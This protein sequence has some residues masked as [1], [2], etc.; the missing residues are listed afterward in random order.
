MKPRWQ[1]ARN[2]T[3]PISISLI[4]QLSMQWF[5]WQLSYTNKTHSEIFTSIDSIDSIDTYRHAYWTPFSEL[6]IN[7]IHINNN[8]IITTD[9]EKLYTFIQL[10]TEI[11]E[12][13]F[14][15][16]L[17]LMNLLLEP[18]LRTQS[19]LFTWKSVIVEDGNLRLHITKAKEA[20]CTYCKSTKD[21]LMQS[22]ERNIYEASYVS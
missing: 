6:I 11:N 13:Y 18:G 20:I 17:G 21:L 7:D 15:L 16:V 5:V 1:N 10:Q 4:T 19:I 12:K 3:T 9:Y 14:C 22:I 8:T 2:W